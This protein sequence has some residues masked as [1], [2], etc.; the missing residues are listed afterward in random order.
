MKLDVTSTDAL[1]NTSDPR[2]SEPPRVDSR[3]KALE[4][5]VDVFNS[6]LESTDPEEY[7]SLVSYASDAVWCGVTNH[8]SDIDQNLTDD[9]ELINTAVQTIGD[10]VF[11][12]GT[13][14]SAGI[15]DAVSVLTDP[16]HARPFAAKTMIVLT[17][18]HPMGGRSP[19]DAAQDAALAGIT[20]H[21]ITFSD[22]ANQT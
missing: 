14:I 22:G 5:A 21:T 8:A 3:W 9:L 19:V 18:G 12:G 10:R 15:D 6:T 11:N 17:D 7:V 16:S 4:D 20:V 1:M 2:F 13:E